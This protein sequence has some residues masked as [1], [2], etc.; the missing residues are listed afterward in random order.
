MTAMQTALPADLHADT[1]TADHARRRIEGAYLWMIA[2]AV[3]LFTLMLTRIYVQ[4][5]GRDR[6]EDAHAS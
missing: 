5:S 2:P 3:V 4:L 1:R 6:V